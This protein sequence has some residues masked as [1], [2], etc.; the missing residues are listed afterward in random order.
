MKVLYIEN[1][2]TCPLCT[3]CEDIEDYICTMLWND[4][5]LTVDDAILTEE[6]LTAHAPSKRCPLD[7]SC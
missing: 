1:C 5:T 7:D 6:E 2:W 3:Y 4:E